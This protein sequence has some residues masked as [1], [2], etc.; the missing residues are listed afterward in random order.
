MLK[1]KELLCKSASVGE[2]HLIRNWFWKCTV[3][4]FRMKKNKHFKLN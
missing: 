1:I 3:N 2:R 4:Q